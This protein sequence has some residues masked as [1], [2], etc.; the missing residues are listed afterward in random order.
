MITIKRSP[1]SP[2]LDLHCH[3]TCS[4]GRLAPRELAARLSEA[5][6]ALVALTDHDTLDG[7]AEF[8]AEARAR[9]LRPLSGVEISCRCLRLPEAPEVH[10][11]AYGVAPGEPRLEALLAGIRR[12]R[13]ERL[14]EMRVRL[15]EL[16]A[17][18]TEEEL[19]AEAAG[20]SAGRPH[21]AR[22]AVRKGYAPTLSQAFD[23][24]LANGRPACVDKTLPDSE[25]V[26]QLVH[27]AGGRVVLAHPGKALPDDAALALIAE[28]V[29]GLEARHPS[30]RAHQQQRFLELAR[31]NR[32]GATGGSDFHGGEREQRYRDPEW[33]LERVGGPLGDWL[34]ARL[35]G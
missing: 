29:D 10:L 18:V 2:R 8:A 3:S 27:E 21:L 19:A 35:K 5:G 12:M 16:G 11:L 9:G 30:H 4:D 32:L 25:E 22:L 1:R 20:A 33:T 23:R 28:G 26:V 15:A 7:V 34:H 6:P 17:L 13:V 31:R 14:E 24:W